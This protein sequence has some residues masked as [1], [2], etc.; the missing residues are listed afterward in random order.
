MIAL[1]HIFALYNFFVPVDALAERADLATLTQQAVP[2]DMVLIPAGLFEMGSANPLA[3]ADEHPRHTVS[4]S[5]FYLDKYEVT[6]R[7]FRKFVKAKEYETTA[8]KTKKVWVYIEDEQWTEVSGAWWRKPEGKESV[9]VSRR[10]SHPVVTVSWEDAKAY[11][12]GVGKRLPTEAEWE[13]AARAGSATNAWWG[14]KHSGSREIGNVADKT[15]K[16]EFPGRPWPILE[17]YDDNLCPNGPCG[18]VRTQYMGALRHDWKC[19]GM[20]GRLVFRKLLR[21]ESKE[22]SS[23][24]SPGPFQSPPR[25][26]LGHLSRVSRLGSSHL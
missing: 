23:R 24:T 2:K 5:A 7:R 13:Y 4:L 3:G 17:H 18:R 20:G 16:R 22:E 1:L 25:R 15:H 14:D 8:E 26:L 6:N 19:M 11:C 21:Q 9:F 12:E 10:G